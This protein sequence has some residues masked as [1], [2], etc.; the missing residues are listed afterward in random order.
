[1]HSAGCDGTT[2]LIVMLLRVQT[3]GLAEDCRLQVFMRSVQE[4][5]WGWT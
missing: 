5:L 2:D 3:T 1:M 4:L